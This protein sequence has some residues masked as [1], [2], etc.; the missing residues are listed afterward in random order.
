MIPANAPEAFQDRQTLWNAVDKF[1]NSSNAQLAREVEI[2]LPVEFTRQEQIKILQEYVKKSFVDRGMCADIC[3]HDRADG[4]PHAHVM[5]TM[6]PINDGQFGEKSRKIYDLDADGNKIYNPVT[7]QYKCHKQNLTDWNR[8]TN[9]EQWR[10]SWAAIC[11][12]EFERKGIPER[13]DHRSYKRQGVE[14]VPTIHLG[15]EAHQLEKRGVRTERGNYNREVER[16]NASYRKT[17]SEVTEQLREMYLQS[18]AREQAAREQAAAEQA[19]KEK[20]MKEQAQRDEREKAGREQAANN[21]DPREREGREPDVAP[22]SQ[23]PTVQGAEET[24]APISAEERNGQLDEAGKQLGEVKNTYFRSVQEIETIGARRSELN[25]E[26]TRIGGNISSLEAYRSTIESNERKLA[27][28]Q[29]DRDQLGAFSFKAK[30]KIDGQ[31]ASVQQ[32]QT[33]AEKSLQDEYS[34]TKDQIPAKLTELQQ[35]ARRTEKAIN[36]LPNV[37]QKQNEADSAEQEYK[38][39]KIGTDVLPEQERQRIEKAESDYLN[40]NQGGQGEAGQGRT[41]QSFKTQAKIDKITPEE[42]QKIK[43]GLP[44]SVQARLNAR[45]AQGGK[46]VPAYAQ[47]G[48][49]QGRTMALTK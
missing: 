27:R 26:T 24:K 45:D 38:T 32:S 3:V 9:A 29:T 22:T 7:K 48:T 19:A 37:E 43:A 41:M 49:T 34:I 4:N 17:V 13:L 1:N 36:D 44:R 5:L 39:K 47:S 6:N 31:I 21:R 33:Q 16:F 30:A 10:E 2:G 20:A 15:Q 46:D 25:H 11:N 28:L 14:K 35:Q 18:Q 40:Q 8:P 12:R 42:Y 23:R